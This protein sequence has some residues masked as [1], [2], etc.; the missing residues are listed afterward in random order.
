MLAQGQHVQLLEHLHPR[1][2]LGAAGLSNA[3]MDGL[4]GHDTIEAFAFFPL[5]GANDWDARSLATYN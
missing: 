3:P 5:W 2:L 4:G 1:L